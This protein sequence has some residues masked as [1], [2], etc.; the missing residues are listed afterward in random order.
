MI[1]PYRH[2]RSEDD[3]MIFHDCATDKKVPAARYYACF[4]YDRGR[5]A[6]AGQDAPAC[7]GLEAKVIGSGPSF[8]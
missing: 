7:P 3:L 5:R 6:G 4:V 1:G 8:G 2:Y